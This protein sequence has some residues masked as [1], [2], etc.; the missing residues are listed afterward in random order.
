MSISNIDTKTTDLE[1]DD[2]N[3]K[4]SMDD[5]IQLWST[6]EKLSDNLSKRRK[7]RKK[8]LEVW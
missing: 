8:K 4:D 3:R 6:L 7:K 1:T 5:A 2:R